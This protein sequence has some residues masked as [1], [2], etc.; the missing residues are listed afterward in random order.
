M[1][2]FSGIKNWLLAPWPWY[3]TG[4]LIGLTV[5]AL[6]LGIGRPLGV[7]SNLQSLCSI[8]L[9]KTGIE[10]FQGRLYAK[11]AWNLFFA[12]G[13][14]IGGFLATWGLS[15]PHND[16][17]AGFRLAVHGVGAQAATLFVGGL[18]VGFGTRWAN[19][20]TSGH[21]IMGIAQLR[22]QSLV[23]TISFFAGGLLL[24]A[25]DGALHLFNR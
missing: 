22:W 23:A 10:Y 5:P 2:D 16:A 20:C 14:V 13:L 1:A 11:E 9:E 8:A 3:V 4:P 7:S 21:S 12:L 25:V 19:G 24:S 17:L 15:S 6:L 18:A